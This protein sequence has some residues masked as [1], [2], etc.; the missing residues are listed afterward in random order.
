M[1]VLCGYSKKGVLTITYWTIK[2]LDNAKT[3]T[4]RLLIRY[5]NTL[6]AI[7]HSVTRKKSGHRPH[8]IT[9]SILYWIAITIPIVLLAIWATITSTILATAATNT[10]PQLFKMNIVRKV[11]RILTIV[12]TVT[13]V[14]MNM[15]SVIEMESVMARKSIGTMIN[16]KKS[17]AL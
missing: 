5:I 11:S 3:A 7:A 15:T 4:S 17:T 16:L 13:K 12:L 6:L 9:P 1:R 10:H 2:R 8:L 14:R